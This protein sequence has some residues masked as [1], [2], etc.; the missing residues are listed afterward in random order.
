MIMIKINRRNIQ[1]ICL[2]IILDILLKSKSLKNKNIKILI[3]I[4]CLALSLKMLFYIKF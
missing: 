2:Y 1:I 4:P 3:L